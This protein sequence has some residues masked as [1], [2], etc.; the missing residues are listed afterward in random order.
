M[1]KLA[2]GWMAAALLA[3]AR[4]ALA[5]APDEGVKA[6]LQ[7]FAKLADQNDVEGMLALCTENVLFLEDFVTY[8]AGS[9]RGKEAF[10]KAWTESSRPRGLTSTL[11][12]LDVRVKGDAA[13][14]VARS[15]SSVDGKPVSV[16]STESY[17]LVQ[18]NGQWR[19]DVYHS[20]MQ[21]FVRSLFYPVGVL[22]MDLV[23]VV[24]AL[25]AVIVL[26]VAR[27]LGLPPAFIIVGV[28][29]FASG[30]IPGTPSVPLWLLAVICGA[31]AYWL[32]RKER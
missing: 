23:L 27:L 2:L 31:I 6:T 12:D 25:A 30:L 14:A 9:P 21:G 15:E 20:S 10:R 24:S 16:P 28:V 26:I 17:F 18:E 11:S 19:L 3:G 29:L 5:Q 8:P 7:Q 13:L 1:R 4:F 22:P 32:R